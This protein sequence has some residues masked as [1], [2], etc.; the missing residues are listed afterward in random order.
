VEIVDSGLALDVLKSHTTELGTAR[1]RMREELHGIYPHRKGDL[2]DIIETLKHFYLL[3]DTQQ[4]DETSLAHDTL[5]PVVIR[6]YSESDK[7]GQRAARILASKIEDFKK[8]VSKT[9]LDENDLEIVEQGKNGMRIFGDDEKK[10]LKMSR[11]RRTKRAKEKKRIRQI[12]IALITII[13]IT[14]IFAL[15]QW[16]T[17]SEERKIVERTYKKAEAN[18]LAA[19]AKEKVKED[20]TIA[21]RIAEAAWKLDKNDTV[22]ETISTIYRNYNFYR[23]LAGGLVSPIYVA[24]SPDGK[25]VLT[26]GFHTSALL[27]NL[28]G[29]VIQKFKQHRKRISSVAFSP[30]GKHVLTGSF[31]STARLWNLEGKAVQEFKGHTEV[32]HSVTFSPD[33]NH[34]LTGSGDSTA[35]LWNLEGKIIQQF[36]GHK[37]YISSVAFSPDGKYVLTGS[38]DS[39]ARLWNL[40]GKIIRELKEHKYP[41]SSV[42]FSPDGKY[43]LTG[44]YEITVILWDLEGNVIREFKN[45]IWI[46]SVAFSPDGKHFLT[47]SWDKTACLWN[48]EGYALEVFT[49]HEDEVHSVAFSPDGKHVLTGSDDGM[50]RLWSLKATKKLWVNGPTHHWASFP[51]GT[52]YP[53]FPGNETSAPPEEV[54]IMPLEEFLKKGNFDQLT[55]RQKKRFGIR[56]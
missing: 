12:G 44:S 14:A 28:E 4:K 41:V 17:A 5:A 42:A 49:G 1:A 37:G 54:P 32:V 29:K 8:E 20:P 11:E 9:S 48:L 55:D 52:V 35:R 30:D 31:D 25:H 15:W 50:V 36:I 38:G 2:D 53:K 22:V 13:I 27:L 19:L 6:E 51:D 33:G 3:T 40:E 39:T 24:F 46:H 34:V 56:E 45:G 23:S 21:L 7:P 16:K 43:I 10:L 47:G 26:S 18:R